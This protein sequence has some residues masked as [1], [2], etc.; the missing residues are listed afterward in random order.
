MMLYSALRK[1]A[2]RMRLA[3]CRV[4]ACC[5]L[6][7]HSSRAPP[8]PDP[9]PFAQA[10]ITMG[11]RRRRIW[12]HRGPLPTST[13]TSDRRGCAVDGRQARRRKEK[14][15]AKQDFMS[16]PREQLGEHA[17]TLG[18]EHA[19]RAYAPADQAPPQP[20][21]TAPPANAKASHGSSRNGAEHFTPY[22]PGV[23]VCV[24]E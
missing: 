23:C 6:L 18:G 12:S 21:Y 20:L 5:S 24:S 2:C 10:L 15:N 22:S 19:E 9:H 3:I 17:N 11:A 7:Q 14:P 4:A 1:F 16:R 8:H 13:A